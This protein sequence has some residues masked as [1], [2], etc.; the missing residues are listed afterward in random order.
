M[1]INAN[2]NSY[3]LGRYHTP[4][5]VLSTSGLNEEIIP[6]WSR[7]YRYPPFT[8]VD[9]ESLKEIDLLFF[10][11]LKARG[12]VILLNAEVMLFT[13]LLYWLLLWPGYQTIKPVTNVSKLGLPQLLM[14]TSE[15]LQFGKS[16]TII[17]YPFFADFFVLDIVEIAKIAEKVKLTKVIGFPLE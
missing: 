3:L 13:T 16:P 9:A 17:G 6:L 1:I 4:G 5:T 11:Q 8:D 2:I 10:P 14:R 12:E 15:A 7:Y